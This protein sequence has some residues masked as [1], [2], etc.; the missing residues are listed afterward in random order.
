M[1]TY[2]VYVTA[3]DTDEAGRIGRQVVEARLAACANILAPMQSI[4]WWQGQIEEA[5]EAVLILK[6]KQPLLE[7]LIERVR[8]LHSYQCPCIVALPIAAGNPA[9]LEW[10]ENE[11]SAKSSS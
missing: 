7:D 1:E 6:T 2:L 5:V 9:Y 4:Y 3:S 10:I 8:Q 11:A